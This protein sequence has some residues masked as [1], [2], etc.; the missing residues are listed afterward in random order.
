MGRK[1]KSL[2]LFRFAF[3]IDVVAACRRGLRTS[4][5]GNKGHPRSFFKI[6]RKLNKPETLYMILSP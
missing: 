4:S 1:V 5:P 6:D 3:N 2:K